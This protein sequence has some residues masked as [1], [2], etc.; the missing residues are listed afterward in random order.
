MEKPLVLKAETD[1]N[2]LHYTD[3]YYNDVLAATHRHGEL[4]LVLENEDRSVRQVI[5][6]W[7]GDNC[8][9]TENGLELSSVIHSDAFT[10]DIEIYLCYERV[11][12]QLYRRI[13]RLHQT[14]IPV[15]FYQ[16]SESLCAAQPHTT[17]WSFDNASHRGGIV[18][19]TYPAIGLHC[20]GVSLGLLT[21]AGHRNLWTRNIRRRPNPGMLGFTAIRKMCD[22]KMLVL[23]EG[24][25]TMTF[26]SMTDYAAGETQA[27]P[28]TPPE[29]W[30]IPAGSRC[31]QVGSYQEIG[32]EAAACALIPYQ[33]ADGCYTLS[34]RY[35][36]PGQL[37]LRVLK[38]QPDSEVR[39]FHYQELPPQ[40]EWSQFSDTFFLSDTEQLPTLLKIYAEDGQLFQI[41][42]LT[43]TC[44]KGVETPYHHL[45]M[46]EAEQK[47]TFIFAQPCETIRDLRLASQLRLAEGLGFTGGE[48]EKVLYAD[49]QM[50]TWITSH[51]DFTPLN[52]PSIN[53]APDMYNRDA[54]WSVCGIDDPY[55]SRAIFTRWGQT[56]NR[57]G[58][59]GTIVTPCMGSIEKKGNDA[60]CEWLWWA[61]VNREKYGFA[62]PEDKIKL[63]FAYCI[64]QFDPA[65]SGICEAHFVLGQN[66]VT[67]YPGERKT[68]NLSLNQGV[69]AVTLQV[70]KRL[71]LP[72]NQ[73]WIDN[74]IA[75]YRSFYDAEKGR[76]I[77]DRL[78][79][80]TISVGD[81]MPEFASLWLLNQPMLSDDM[82]INTLE[83][84]PRCG[85]CAMFI[86]NTETEFFTL[87]NLPCDTGYFWPDG[88]YYNGGSWMREEIMAYAAGKRHGWAQADERIHAR[89]HAEINTHPDQPFSHEF[90]PT[91]PSVP[92]C[93]WPS[94]RVFCWNVFSLTAL[95]VAG[96]RA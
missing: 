11:N 74:A 96:L 68:R 60:T 42:D 33:L 71:G 41:S 10:A 21:D 61:Y 67:T 45:R 84:I 23:K 72:V 87:E 86:S 79:P 78:F 81:L 16:V 59:I 82:V 93:W 24:K 30:I 55:L 77:N 26:G 29:S 36:N 62:P 58:C 69:W 3:I 32:G 2:G 76:L 15:L 14:N 22:A 48:T 56:Q 66:D 31:T 4:D 9:I 43:L 1:N 47:T 89:L 50:L 13:V 8:R 94:I 20:G 65:R 12:G 64:S 28:P 25:A 70:A 35:R 51:V 17:C 27:I 44:H 53:Y 46:G 40:N 90:I 39:A 49:M 18:H 7:K 63:A 73:Q 54:F 34:F 75:G 80:D 19:G 83:K 5:S 38:N 37:S 95:E 91:D 88:I 92:G 85:A 6:G 57:E 52:V